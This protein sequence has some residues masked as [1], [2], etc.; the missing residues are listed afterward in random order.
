MSIEFL[1]LAILLG[2]KD[3]ADSEKRHCSLQVNESPVSRA[4]E[5]TAVS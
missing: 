4:H 3:P 1:N 5:L 2:V